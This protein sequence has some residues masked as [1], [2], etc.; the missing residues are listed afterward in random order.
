MSTTQTLNGRTILLVS[1]C[2]LGSDDRS[3][4]FSR[5]GRHVGDAC[6]R[7]L[8]SRGA[9]VVLVDSQHRS[10]H[11]LVEELRDSG[12]IVTPVVADLNDFD[13]LSAAA[14]DLASHAL[15]PDALVCSH[16]D[17]ERVSLEESSPQSWRRVMDFNVLGPVFAVKAFLPLLKQAQGAAIVHIGSI[18]G[19]LGN[20]QIPSYSAAKGAIVALTHVMAAELSCYDIRVNCVARALIAEPDE[21]LSHSKFPNIRQTPIGRAGT[22]GEVAAAVRFLISDEASYITGAVLPVDGGRSGVTPGTWFRPS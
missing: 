2:H 19:T 9:H 4:D 11:R 6:A 12:G 13:S 16:I 14:Q 5:Y 10:L 3:R 18:D 1:V 7:D 15:K 17:M 8:A 22:P 20:P 21:E